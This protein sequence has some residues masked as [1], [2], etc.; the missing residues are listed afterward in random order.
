LRGVGRASAA[1]TIVNALP[2]GVG[3]ALGIGLY[4]TAEV[5][6]RPRTSGAPNDLRMPAELRTPL[7]ESALRAALDHYGLPHGID[8]E[9]SLRSEIPV[10]RGLKSSSAVTSAVAEA[11]ARAAGRSPEPLETARLSAEVSKAVGASATGALDDALAGLV[12]GFVV[13]DS[14]RG[15]VLRTGSADP[16]WEV[17]LLIPSGT[18]RPSPEWANEFE[19]HARE[20][21]G[22]VDAALSR[23]WWGA[24]ARNTELVERTMH[25]E[26]AGVREDLRRHG[27][28][29]S[30]VSGLGPALAA[31]APRR[32]VRDLLEV[33]PAAWGERR[34]VPL[35][36]APPMDAGRSL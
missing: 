3:C 29:G 31:V 4:A 1:I 22:A 34:S 2:T 27:A 16:D 24:M 23:D 30:G 26:Y 35:T 11:V 14:R 9:L 17:A 18:H 32:Q 6:L 33:L 5:T 8:A 28:L 20:G 25:Y 7:V 10:S 36:T 13:T 21:Q 19:A 15:T 12:R